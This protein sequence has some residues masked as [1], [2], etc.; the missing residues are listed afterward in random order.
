MTTDTPPPSP[1]PPRRTGHRVALALAALLALVL[2]LGAGLAAWVWH[3]EAGSRWALAHVPG[4]TIEDWQGA[5]G[6]GTLG[7]ARLQLDLGAGTLTLQGLRLDGL[8]LAWRPEPGLW[9]RVQAGSLHADLLR[10]QSKPHEATPSSGPPTQLRLPLALR[11]PAV[12]VQRLLVNTVEPLTEVQLNLDLGADGGARHRLQAALQTRLLKLDGQLTLG[13]DAPLSTEARLNLHSRNEDALPIAASAHLSGP[14]AQLA[15]QADLEGR[16]MALHAAGAIKPFAAWPLGDFNLTSQ[17]LDLAALA[18]GAPRTQLDVDASVRTAG[19]D[20][21]AAVKLA[22]RNAAPGRWDQG[23]LPVRSLA[24]EVG[25]TPTP[26]RELTLSRLAIELVAGRIEGAGRIQLDGERHTV[27]LALTATDV[28]PA[29]LDERAPAMRLGGPLTL[30]ARDLTTYPAGAWQAGVQ[31]RLRGQLIGPEATPVALTLDASAGAGGLTLT[32]VQAETGAA[33]AS[34]QGRVNGPV[35]GPGRPWQWQ[36]DGALREFDPALW[37]PGEPGSAWRAGPHR[38]HLTLRSEGSLATLPTDPQAAWQALRGSVQAE[39]QDSLLAGV[40]LQGRLAAQLAGPA[41]QGD[42]TLQ[43]GRNR[44]TLQLPANQPLRLAL[45]APHLADWAPLARLAPAAAAWAPTQGEA[46][47]SLSL[48]HLLDGQPVAWQ[49]QGEIRTLHTASA[50]LGQAQWQGQGSLDLAAPLALKLTAADLTQGEATRLSHLALDVTGSLGQH[51]LTLDG[52][53]PLRPP[54]WVDELLAVPSG[55][56]SRLNL[57]LAGTWTATAAQGQPWWQ[58]GRWQGRVE[59]LTL[60]GQGGGAAWLAGRDLALQAAWTAAG[61]QAASVQPGRLQLPG[62]ALVWRE[63]GWT[64][65]RWAVDADVEG[66]ALTPLLARAQPGQGWRGDLQ[67]GGHIRLTQ[68]QRFDADVVFERQ[69][70]DLA[71]ATDPRAPQ[72]AARSLG[73]SSLRLALAAH[74]GRWQFVPSLSGERLGELAGVLAVQT[75]ASQPWPHAEAP[76]SGVLQMRIEQ[77][78]AWAPWL[79]PGWRVDGELAATAQF[80]GRFGAPQVSGQLTGRNVAVRNLLEGVAL[81]EGQ[82]DIGFEGARADIRRFAF[83]GGD[84]T[85]ALT[86]D[87]TLGERPMAH[88]QATLSRFQALGRIDRRVIVSGQATVVADA[89]RIAVEG[90]VGV[91]EGLIDISQ[92]GGPTLASDITV[93]GANDPAPAVDT[94]AAPSAAARALALKL[95]LHLGQKLRLKGRGIDT[96]L[97]GDLVLT[98]PEGR[99]ELRGTVRTQGGLYAAYGQRLVIQRGEV[100]F[101]GPIMTPR[102]DI[103]AVR[104]N[105]DIL[106]GVAVG[107]RPDSP[108]VRLV[109]E[110]EMSDMDKLSWLMLG[111]APE[112]LGQADTA[113]L[114]RA[115]MA[116]LSGEEEGLTDAMMRNLGLTDFGVSQNDDGSV[117]DTVVS[118]GRQLSQRWYIGY[119]HSVNKASGTWQLIYRV[120]RRFTLRLNAG[121]DDSS[122]DAI[123]MW[124]WD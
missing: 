59:T 49:T 67:L 33:Q 15:L 50:N 6:Q 71:L 8:A 52:A 39:L 31:T 26:L 84:G 69:S 57:A 29:L 51:R 28:Q 107:G 47:A 102:L 18:D 24:L 53:S 116:I 106:V 37:W 1:A 118:L 104:P 77:L 40:P 76:L 60:G 99:P 122:V 114:Q 94:T 81:T 3:S 64:P 63:A 46:H 73:L 22:A 68:A 19:L 43:A 92:G 66:F 113:L 78:A 25:G 10:W 30:T 48:A 121:S 123:W 70:G 14:L 96:G 7:A 21:P 16:G 97:A 89:N 85:L 13:S 75:T 58:A 54:E 44:L 38:L 105:L 86:G 87:A 35:F 20:Q 79:P 12:T 65:A 111:R 88:L 103:L 98:S 101:S 95:N 93:V 82:I 23:A 62:T 41:T 100:I 112:G 117:R 9:L 45:E 36:V 108:Q 34:L 72:G 4:L 42:G 115:A 5:P 74:D 124:R 55:G 120:A 2:A 56:G 109:S 90:E 91:D 110:P 11:I 61:L 27:Q 83:K 119:E 17:A 80:D 32:T